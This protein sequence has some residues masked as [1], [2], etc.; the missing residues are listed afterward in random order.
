VVEGIATA[1]EVSTFAVVYA[2]VAGMLVYGGFDWRRMYP[3]LVET[4][5]LSGAVLLIVGTAHGMAWSLAQ[6][7][8]AQSLT[9]GMLNLPGGALTYMAVT[10]VV[11]IVLGCV[12]EGLPALVLLGPLMF[13]IAVKLGINDVQYA[14]VVIVAMNIGLFAP[15][16]GIGYYIACSIGRVSPDAALRAVWPYLFALLLGLLVIATVPWISTSVL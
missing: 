3:A 12:L 7:G 16:I 6:S 8:F 5:A 15:P 10:V 2:L 11:F 14:M 4:A 13:P 1:T 9:Q